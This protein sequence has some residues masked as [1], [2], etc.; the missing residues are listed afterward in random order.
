MKYFKHIL[1][2]EE[3]ATS[4]RIGGSYYEITPQTV[5][6]SLKCGP[7]LRV[8]IKKES[9]YYG[10]HSIYN[11][12]DVI[13]TITEFSPNDPGYKKVP[14]TVRWD[15]GEINYYGYNDLEIVE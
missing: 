7:P 14:L 15:N 3:W 8:R 12:K 4:N 10:S 9:S 5:S 1:E 6:D 2:M 13:G 11:P